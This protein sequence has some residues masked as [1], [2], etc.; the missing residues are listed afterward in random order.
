MAYMVT[1]QL[2]ED[3]TND[4]NSTANITG[5]DPGD[6]VKGAW[7]SLSM[8]PNVP[9]TAQVTL[10]G[11]TT[12]SYAE[13]NN[14]LFISDAAHKNAL[15]AIVEAQKTL[16]LVNG[17]TIGKVTLTN[18]KGTASDERNLTTLNINGNGNLTTIN[19]I[20]TVIGSDTTTYATRVNVNS[21]ADVTGDIT[22]V[23]RVNVNEGATLHVY[24]S[25]AASKDVP[26]V[27][28][29]TLAVVNGTA[30][31]DG[32]LIID[33]QY[34]SST[35]D[36]FGGDGEAYAIGG[37]ITATNIELEHDASLTT[38]HSGLISAETVTA[39]AHWHWLLRDL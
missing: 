31:I 34:S 39:V 14:G 29:N 23:G 12:L 18:G 10:A 22:G 30:Q 7:G 19:G 6:E 24:N 3:V 36:G 38:V 26:E 17:G 35:Y 5:I 1:P 37:S 16:N 21:D 2:S 32:D 8:T 11:N 28:V 4:M 13:G 15:G 25:D 9:S 20:D 33:G 27:L